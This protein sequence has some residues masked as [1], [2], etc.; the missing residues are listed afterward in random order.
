MDRLV[1]ASLAV[2]ERSRCEESNRAGN[3][4]CLV[5]QDVSEHIRCDDYIEERRVADDLHRRI[6]DI[7]VVESDIRIFGLAESV[8]G[9]A[10]EPGCLK[11]IGFVH[12]CQVTF[13]PARSLKSSS[14]YT[15][16]L[17]D[18]VGFCIISSISG[19]VSAAIAEID[20]ARQ[21]S[22]DHKVKALCRYVLS[23]DACLRKRRLY[24]GRSEVGVKTESFAQSEQSFFR[25]HMVRYFVPLRSAYCSEQ[26]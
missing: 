8:Y 17:H 11:D 2:A 9:L 23:E 22:Y 10:P 24:R 19:F 25:T 6:V 26:D 16:D 4:R 15:L 14:C 3:L 13:A 21:F 18:A 7:H 12:A 5:R 1:H 20:P